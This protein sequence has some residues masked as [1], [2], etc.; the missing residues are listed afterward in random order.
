VDQKS[1]KLLDQ[2][3]S[4]KVKETEADSVFTNIKT[5]SVWISLVC[6]SAIVWK[7]PD[8]CPESERSLS[9]KETLT[10]TMLSSKP[11]RP[12]HFSACLLK[13]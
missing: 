12:A 1:L 2:R 5:V 8:T 13:H 7:S 6:R 10:G 9:C 4:Q 11:Q 3:H